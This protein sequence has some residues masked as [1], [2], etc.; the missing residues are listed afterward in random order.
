MILVGYLVNHKNPLFLHSKSFIRKCCAVFFEG[1]LPGFRAPSIALAT[2]PQESEIQRLFISSCTVTGL[3]AISM[4]KVC[5]K[6]V[7]SYSYRY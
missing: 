6:Y 1:F 3:V 4:L 2:L 7:V 5:Y